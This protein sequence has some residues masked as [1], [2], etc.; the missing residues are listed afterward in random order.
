[1]DSNPI[2]VSYFQAYLSYAEYFAST[3]P[4]EIWGQM[5]DPAPVGLE[6]QV[7]PE[8]GADATGSAGL[9]PTGD[10][11]S[12]DLTITSF[13]NTCSDGESFGYFDPETGASVLI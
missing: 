1:M 4:A 3:V 5:P 10:L 2:F 11:Y 8:I 6:N 9:E 12:G 13:G 7:L